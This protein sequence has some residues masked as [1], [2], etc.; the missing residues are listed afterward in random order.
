MQRFILS[1]ICFTLSSSGF[2]AVSG[3]DQ[4]S[5]A[6]EPSDGS[7]MLT[8]DSLPEGQELIVAWALD[9]F[10]QA[11]LNRPAVRLVGH[12][13][14]E[15]CRGRNGIA[16]DRG[17]HTEIGLCTPEVA[18]HVDFL[19][20]HE[21]VHAYEHQFVSDDVRGE[22]LELRGLEQWR[23]SDLAWHEAGAEHAAEILVWGLM[24]RP[25]W[26]VRIDDVSCEELMEGYDT[27]TGSVPVHG[28]TD[29][30]D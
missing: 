22:F 30:C 27:L 21:L 6:V 25:V 13:D 24:D 28:Y 20:L 19:I 17:D 1:I 10:D 5:S 29:H 4:V 14:P 26:I 3:A 15:A 23:G 2:N 16:F 8:I 12:D 7:P 18:A 9:L 11:G